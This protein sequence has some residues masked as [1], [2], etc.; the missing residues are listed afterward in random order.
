M[1]EKYRELNQY[2]IFITLIHMNSIFETSYSVPENPPRL[3]DNLFGVFTQRGKVI[4][5]LNN[6]DYSL[7]YITSSKPYHNLFYLFFRYCSIFYC[8][9]SPQI[10]VPIYNGSLMSSINNTIKQLMQNDMIGRGCSE[11]DRKI[12]VKYKFTYMSI[13]FQSFVTKTPFNT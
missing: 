13:I 8:K 2:L 4:L 7:L 6:S 9:Y 10:S 5:I 12:P 11:P 1:P 3:E